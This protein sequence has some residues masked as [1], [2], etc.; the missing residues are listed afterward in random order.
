MV[1]YVFKYNNEY[2]YLFIETKEYDNFFKYAVV[3]RSKIQ[4]E[5]RKIMLSKWSHSFKYYAIDVISGQ[6]LASDD[7][8]ERLHKRIYNEFRKS[9]I[10]LR[11]DTQK[12]KKLI[13]IR[14]NAKSC[15]EICNEEMT[16]QLDGALDEFLDMDLLNLKLER[17]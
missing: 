3:E 13:D 7:N 17:R 14:N 6:I 10:N 5:A 2:H 1:K 4:K 16:N 11:N 8:L 9:I 15:Y 12:M